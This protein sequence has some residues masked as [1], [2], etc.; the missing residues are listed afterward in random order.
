MKTRR[1]ARNELVV[2][3]RPRTFPLPFFNATNSLVSFAAAF[4]R[5][6]SRRYPDHQP[7]TILAFGLRA[8]N[9][10]VNRTADHNRKGVSQWNHIQRY[11]QR[12]AILSKTSRSRRSASWLWS[13]RSGSLPPA[14]IIRMASA[15]VAV[16]TIITRATATAFS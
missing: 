16:G 15:S 3:K 2:P 12:R 9:W 4:S 8:R 7:I 6:V 11:R 10:C 5:L 13:W 1:L 14:I